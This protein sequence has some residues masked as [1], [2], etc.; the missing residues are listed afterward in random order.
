MK[1]ASGNLIK[2]IIL[3]AGCLIASCGEVEN[4]KLPTESPDL[5]KT[6]PTFTPQPAEL[7]VVNNGRVAFVSEQN[8]SLDIF[9]VNHNGSFLSRL[10]S[11]PADDHSPAW[12]PDGKFIAFVSD[13]EGNQDLF[14]LEVISGELR[15]LTWIKADDYDP[16]WSPDGSKLVYVSDRDGRSNVYVLDIKDQEIEQLT[17]E[18]QP[19]YQP[20]WSPTGEQIVFISERDGKPEIYVMRVD[21]SHQQ[22]LT[23]NDWTET[24]PLWSTDGSQIIFIVEHEKVFEFYVMT[25]RGRNIRQLTY[26]KTYKSN[27]TWLPDGQQI[28]FSTINDEGEWSLFSLNPINGESALL[29]ESEFSIIQPTWSLTPLVENDEPWFGIPKFVG[30]EVGEGKGLENAGVTRERVLL[31]FEF[32]NMRVGLPWRHIWIHETGREIVNAGFWEE[33][34]SGEYVLRYKIPYEDSF[35]IW[36]VQLF[37]GDMLVQE[38]SVDLDSND[39]II[40]D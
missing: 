3:F 7:K 14:L 39:V 11:H 15:D 28:L 35:G 30:I 32:Y 5:E 9:T 27:S 13:R 36:R 19:D 37:I 38:S 17:D 24:H 23:N 1:I 10:I 25:N 31:S 33:V 8:G 6:V 4:N 18:E 22:R 29:L 26:S 40:D 21:G 34:E 2:I 20:H 16:E 12:S